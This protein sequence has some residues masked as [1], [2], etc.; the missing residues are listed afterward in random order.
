MLDERG[1]GVPLIAPRFR[2]FPPF[3]LLMGRDVAPGSTADVEWID[4]A[5]SH[6][7]RRPGRYTATCSGKF[8]FEILPD[9]AAAADGDPIGRLLPLT[10]KGWAVG[11]SARVEPDS[12]RGRLVRPG[13]NWDRV[14]GREIELWPEK[15]GPRRRDSDSIRIWLTAKKASPA[16]WHTFLGKLHP[17]EYA[18]KLPHWHVYL[19]VPPKALERWPTA[20]DDILLALR[21]E[22]QALPPVPGARPA[23]AP[24]GAG[25][26]G[27]GRTA[28]SDEIDR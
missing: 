19:S 26:E 28:Y 20:R 4:L 12:L 3:S 8:T 17:A 5:A 23:P 15:H 25:R 22:P 9:P 10:K 14:P 16:P 11:G 6:Y 24:A 27:A 18:G 1:N 13:S 21:T 7:L 2:R